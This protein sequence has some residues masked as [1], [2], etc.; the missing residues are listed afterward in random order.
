[1]FTRAEKTYLALAL[2]FLASGSGIRAWRRATIG[3]GP[4]PD[5]AT[6][7]LD[8]ARTADSAR[9]SDAIPV[10]ADAPAF[11]PAAADTSVP[12]RVQGVTDPAAVKG[13]STPRAA[14]SL[15]GGKTD[16]NL[17]DAAGLMRVKGIG[18]KTA[19]AIVA[20]R[21]E[22]GPFRALADLLNIKGIGEKKLEKLAPHLIL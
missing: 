13:R 14:A 7:S 9:A 20:Y 3:L 8:S 10:P 6:Q 16:L 21:R 22:H 5:A 4:F 11:I 17:A 1:M 18:A 15:S 12:L 2:A 19:E